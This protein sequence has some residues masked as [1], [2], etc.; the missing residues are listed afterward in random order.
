M[1]AFSSGVLRA[2]GFK[3]IMNHPKLCEK[4]MQYCAF[5]SSKT[6]RI[7][8]FI[9]MK[10]QVDYYRF[11][12][13]D[14]VCLKAKDSKPKTF[15]LYLHGGAYMEQPIV[16]QWKFIDKLVH[17][18]DTMVIAPV[19]NKTPKNTYQQA[20]DMLNQVYRKIL[21]SVPSDNVIFLG[22]SSGGGL[23]LAFA[24]S[25]LN[26]DLPQPQQ[27]ILFS[28]WLD[29]SMEN[30]D[31]DAYDKLDPSLG[32]IGL[33]RIAE[34]WASDTDLHDPKLSPLF[35][36]NKGLANTAIFVGDRE[37]LLPDARKY[38]DIAKKDGVVLTYVEQTG[39]NHC[40]PFYPT[41][42]ANQ[43][44]IYVNNLINLGRI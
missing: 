5:V 28:P 6:Y 42:E 30:N 44:R 16:F 3:I 29:I 7:P 12:D 25:L 11:A 33:R 40:Y 35:G 18:T 4:Y 36:S 34:C 22:D 13:T 24:K 9:S 32:R 26:T 15:I 20:Y 38:R 2:T 43:A 1:S 37:I 14:I 19:Y 21:E 31:M 41:P 10:S 27:L 17:E 23:A 39:V 8:S